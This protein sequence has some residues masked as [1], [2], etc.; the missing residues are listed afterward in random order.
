MARRIG[1]K[2]LGHFSKQAAVSMRSGLTLSRALPIITRESRDRLLRSTMEEINMNISGGETLADALRRQANRFPRIFV[3][4]I[5]SGERTG[6]LPEIFQRLADYF[7]MRLRIR[8]AVIRASIYPAIQ[9]GF[10]LGVLGLFLYL[11]YTTNL[12]IGT[13]ATQALIVAI[14]VGTIIGGLVAFVFFSRTNIGRI[15]WDHIVLGLPVFRS[16]TIKLNM[17][18]FTRTLAMQLES[19][20]PVTEA[21]ERS[22]LVAG[23]RVVARSLKA[24]A[25]PVRRGSSLA[26]AV[27]TSRYL[28]PMVREVI[29]V[30]EETGSFEDSLHRIANIYEE[31][32]MLVLE[33]VPKLIGLPILIIVGLIVIYLFYTVYIGNYLKL[34]SS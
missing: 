15:I 29:T 27:S 32:A 24:M 10:A 21:V 6:H 3:E 14:L 11:S 20:I 7:D 18:R 4:M 2:S 1:L 26:E 23:N 33:T 17:V 13:P 8:R 31:E 16:L 34:L 22:A 28:T 30:S 9:L 5:A 25:E 19:A 12:T